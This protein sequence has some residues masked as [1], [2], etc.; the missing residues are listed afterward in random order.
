M[1]CLSKSHLYFNMIKLVL[2]LVFVWQFVICHAQ[3]LLPCEMRIT[4]VSELTYQ[5]DVIVYFHQSNPHDFILLDWGDESD[6][7]T[8]FEPLAMPCGNAMWN[9]YSYSGTHTYLAESSYEVTYVDSFLLEGVSNIDDSQSQNLI[10]K[11]TVL[12]SAS[13]NNNTPLFSACPQWEWGCC[14]WVY[15]TGCFDSDGDSMSIAL[16]A[17]PSVSYQFQSAQID[18][19]T[20]DFTWEPDQFGLYAFAIE[21][22]DWREVNGTSTNISKVSRYLLLN[23]NSIN[24]EEQRMKKQVGFFPNPVANFLSISGF[25]PNDKTTIKITDTTGRLVMTKYNKQQ[26]DVAHLSSGIYFIEVLMDESR[27]VLRFVKE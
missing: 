7:D 21:L 3:D 10:L 1:T 8:L 4:H 13:I 14:D 6:L 9:G 11:S 27:S 15:N 12:V 19:Q 26:I 17:L 20:F 25:S 16:I 2:A 5:T 24:M 23:V 22:S 18:P